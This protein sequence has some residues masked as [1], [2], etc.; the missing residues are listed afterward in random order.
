MRQRIRLP[1]RRGF[2]LV[3]L[4]VVMAL[5]IFIMYVLA[6]AFAAGSAVFRRLKAIGDMN[7]RLRTATTTLRRLLAADHF[8]GKKRLSDPG[9]WTDGPPQQGFFRIWQDSRDPDPAPP[10]VLLPPWPTIFPEGFDRTLG[11]GGEDL[12][13]LASYR[14]TR[15]HLHFTARLRGNNRGDFFQATLPIGSPLAR[16]TDFANWPPA[17][18]LPRPDSR[19]QESDNV[20]LSPW[21]EIAL[22]L[23][24]SWI[25]AQ[26]TIQETTDDPQATTGGPLPLYTLY[27]RQRLLRPMQTTTVPQP[28][29]SPTYN[30]PI[31]YAIPSPG[32]VTTTPTLNQELSITRGG[33]DPN[34]AKPPP[35]S[36]GPDDR[37]TTAGRGNT[38]AQLYFNTPADVTMPIRRFGWPYWVNFPPPAQPPTADV[39][40]FAGNRSPGGLPAAVNPPLPALPGYPTYVLATSPSV[41]PGGSRPWDEPTDLA[42]TDVLLTD[43]ISMDIR[44]LLDDAAYTVTAT[45]TGPGNPQTQDVSGLPYF[46]SLH[47]EPYPTA[48]YNDL[49][50]K[51]SQLQPPGVWGQAPRINT[52][53]KDK[54]KMDRGD[55][56]QPPLVANGPSR[57]ARVFDTWSSRK[58]D[59]YTKDPSAT[60][61]YTND[62]SEW[63]QTNKPTTI[64]MFTRDGSKWAPIRIRAIQITLR[65]WD[66]KT[67]QSRQVSLV[68]DL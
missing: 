29:A 48:I 8:E 15:H 9:F 62:Y 23:Q 21:A 56:G 49:A 45:R 5:V 4:M 13:G 10:P 39:P 32:T 67:K 38:A 41:Q 28:N 37:D 44:V 1:N 35:V 64:P 42:G 19:F 52:I 17:P 47:D 55:L 14:S 59:L 16:P 54:Y 50:T 11:V 3:E 25:D 6:E 36:W 22:Y 26:R 65:I 18:G 43:V 30:L 12:D 58:D 33:F 27:L 57:P 7:A 53:I 34:A 60:P 63:N 66:S 24:P 46:M 68:Q 40:D 51:W 20:Y 2:T 61:R 31:E